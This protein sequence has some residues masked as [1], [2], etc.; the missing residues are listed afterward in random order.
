MSPTTL[1]LGLR[2]LIMSSSLSSIFHFFYPRCAQG[3]LLTLLTSLRSTRGSWPTSCWRR[4]IPLSLETRWS[5]R[6]NADLSFTCFSF[7][8]KVT[9]KKSL[10][11]YYRELVGSSGRPK[12]RRTVLLSGISCSCLSR[13]LRLLICVRGRVIVTLICD[14]EEEYDRRWEIS[15]E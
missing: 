3:T 12:L 15:W 14:L 11:Y 5:F 9:P 13:V 7:V 6:I 4:W 1:A 2:Y 8:L 10:T